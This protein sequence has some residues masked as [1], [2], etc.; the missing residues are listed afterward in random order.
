MRSRLE[1]LRKEA[2]ILINHR[3][4][5]IAHHETFYNSQL[6]DYYLAQP[7][8]YFYVLN[9]CFCMKLN[10]K[11]ENFFYKLHRVLGI[12]GIG[13]LHIGGE[14]AE[15]LFNDKYLGKEKSK[16]S[17]QFLHRCCYKDCLLKN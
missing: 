6:A 2:N 14:D 5:V 13:M 1:I 3:N 4:K 11:L 7:F 16:K 8:S 17:I 15:K 10:D 9:P 12:N